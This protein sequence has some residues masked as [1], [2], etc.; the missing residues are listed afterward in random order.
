[1]LIGQY[2]GQ[3]VAWY[4]D[5][6]KITFECFAGSFSETFAIG[7]LLIQFCSNLQCLLVMP[8]GISVSIFK[9]IG[10]V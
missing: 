5:H 8:I 7:K 9:V 1:M 3:P 4:L 10:Y 6:G 2:K